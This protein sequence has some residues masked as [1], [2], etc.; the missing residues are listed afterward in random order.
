MW[1]DV[2]GCLSAGRYL[3]GLKAD[4]DHVEGHCTPAP[5]YIYC[6]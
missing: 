4:L 5:G 6:I 2:F 1:D 3:S